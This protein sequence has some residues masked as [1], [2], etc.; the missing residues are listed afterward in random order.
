MFWFNLFYDYFSKLICFHFVIVLK[1]NTP[2]IP[3]KPGYFDYKVKFIEVYLQNK[4]YYYFT[5]SKIRASCRSNIFRY[6]TFFVIF[7]CWSNF[8]PFDFE[9]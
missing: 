6:G 8:G 5:N 9:M 3:F 4:S 1:N 7:I 2:C